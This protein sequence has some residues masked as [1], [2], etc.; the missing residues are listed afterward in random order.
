MIVSTSALGFFYET[1]KFVLTVPL[2]IATW[3]QVIRARQ[4]LRRSRDLVVHSENCLEFV[5]AR[6]DCVNLVPL[7]TL[8]SLPRPGD[9]VLLPGEGIASTGAWRI[10]RIEH[11]Y[12]PSPRKSA[13]PQEA[14]MTKAM[15]YVVSLHDAEPSGGCSPAEASA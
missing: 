3:Y 8:R 10:E 7:E 4:D 5:S 13:R 11:I 14:R 9:I 1:F 15:A 12:T 6:G 2:S